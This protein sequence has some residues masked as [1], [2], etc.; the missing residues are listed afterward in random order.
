MQFIDNECSEAPSRNGPNG[1]RAGG[2]TIPQPNTIKKKRSPQSDKWCFTFNNYTEEEHQQILSWCAEDPEVKEYVIGEEVGEQGTPHLQG[3]LRLTKRVRLPFWK[4]KYPKWH[5]EITKDRKASIVYCSKD[6]KYKTNLH[7]PK[8]IK[9]ISPDRPW[10]LEI[11]SI[12]E[13]PI[14]DRKIYWY[15][16]DIGGIGKT[17][18][19]KYLCVKHRAIV[20]SGKRGDCFHQIAKVIEEG[21]HPELII[22]DI[23]RVA[24]DYV[25]WE[26]LEKVKDGLL[27]SGKY[28]GMQCIF[29]PPHVI[30]FAN[31]PPAYEKLS[32]DRWM[33]KELKH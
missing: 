13:G 27:F 16:E 8:P 25:S 5:V 23:P 14:D 30:C 15:W 10:Q 28:E 32:R 26:A 33:V 11:L 22:F 29:N 7:V 3:Y 4:K 1:P 12:L 31:Q 2:N 20:L 9:L 6:G 18:F 21:E 19:T 24:K 17:A